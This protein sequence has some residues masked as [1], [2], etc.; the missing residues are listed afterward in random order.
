MLL[1]AWLLLRLL[2]LPLLLLLYRG[3]C[4][5]SVLLWLG[6]GLLLLRLLLCCSSTIAM[7]GVPRSCCRFGAE[8]S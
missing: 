5:H 1:L 8:V 2:L 6:L 4:F 7:H 3:W